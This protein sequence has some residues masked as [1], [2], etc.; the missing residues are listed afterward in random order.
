MGKPTP[1]QC[2]GDVLAALIMRAAQ[3][4]HW[5]LITTEQDTIQLVQEIEKYTCLY[6]YTVKSYSNDRAKTAAW[7]EVSKTVNI[8]V[9]DCKE[10]WRNIRGRYLRQVKEQPPSGSGSKRKKKDYYLNEY[11]QFIEPFTKSRPQTGNL[12]T[13]ENNNDDTENE[14]DDEID[15]DTSII[16][17][18]TSVYK[19]KIIDKNE[20]NK[21]ATNYFTNK[22]LTKDR[23]EETDDPDMNFLKSLLP[24]IKTLNPKVKRILKYDMMKLVNDANEQMQMSQQE[25][26]TATQQG[27]VYQ[28][29]YD[30]NQPQDLLHHQRETHNSTYDTNH[31]KTQLYQQ[32]QH[33]P[34][35]RPL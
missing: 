28:P 32:E 15:I 22:K 24:D 14:V 8:S 13:Q 35:W 29:L 7:N 6:D 30:F 2:G 33:T 34:Y 17:Q 27:T 21:V 16:C 10:K 20:L 26:N 18:E 23:D 4:S 11:L 25:Q 3:T 9:S 1:I 31:S 5:Q 19:P 12:Q